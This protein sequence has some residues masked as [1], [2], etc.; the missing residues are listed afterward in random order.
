MQAVSIKL[1]LVHGSPSGLRTA[2]ISNW[3]GK[4]ISAPRTELSDFLNRQELVNPGI[5]FLTGTD[6]ESG[7][8]ALYIGEAESVTSRVKSHAS[9]EFWINVTAFVSKDEN[10]TKSHIRYLEGKL[11]EFASKV[12]DI[13]LMNSA[14]SG[15][16]LPESDKA[17]MDVYLD[18]VFQR[19][20]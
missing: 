6:E 17:E 4:A 14:S 1:F 8:Q 7:N 15:A 13:A 10:L 2:E 19:K 12:P 3:T 18:K 16:K 5:Y 20:V 9:K 11:I